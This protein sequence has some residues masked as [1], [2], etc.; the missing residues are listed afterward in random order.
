V[1]DFQHGYGKEYWPDGSIYEGEYIKGMKSGK[2]N[3]YFPDG[4]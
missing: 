2:G 1:N 4:S 3:I